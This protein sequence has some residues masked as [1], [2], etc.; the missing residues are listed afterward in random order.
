MKPSA[1]INVKQHTSR[2][3]I[4]PSPR[5]GSETNLRE[6]R[7]NEVSDVLKC[8]ELRLS[9]SF[10]SRHLDSPKPPRS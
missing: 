3:G 1:T 6:G 2:G 7:A 9:S 10:V 8:Y 5:G 4:L